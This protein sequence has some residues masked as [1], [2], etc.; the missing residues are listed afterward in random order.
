M[1]SE[2]RLGVANVDHR[3]EDDVPS[4]WV[5][6][7]GVGEHASVPADMLNASRSGV[8]EPI[9]RTF[10]DVELAVGII[11]R[12]M[13]ARLVVLSGAMNLPTPVKKLMTAVATVM[14]QTAYR[15]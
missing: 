11:G 9:A 4:I 3:L 2:G 8:L 15:L 7:G 10:R 5:L 1:P 14:T 6:Q 12:A 13:F